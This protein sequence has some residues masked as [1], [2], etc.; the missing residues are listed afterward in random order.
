MRISDNGFS[1]KE[2][3]GF[4]IMEVLSTGITINVP[5]TIKVENS[6]GSGTS[7][8]VIKKDSNGFLRLI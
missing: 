4:T 3:S 6:E 8:G 7:T 1:F 5:T 2:S